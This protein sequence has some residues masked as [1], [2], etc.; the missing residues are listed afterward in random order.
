LVR[1]AAKIGKQSGSIVEIEKYLTQEEL[2]Q[3]VAARR[4][5]A[6]T[7]LNF[8]RR[9]GTVRYLPHGHLSLN[10]RVLESHAT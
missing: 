7:T 1:L 3:M 5:R 4:E 8:L 6:S 10:I 9:Q 2:A